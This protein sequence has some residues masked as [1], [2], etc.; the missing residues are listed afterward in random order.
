MF[1]GDTFQEL[2]LFI[3]HR[4]THFGLADKEFPGEGVV[5]GYGLVD[6]RPVY[7]ASQD[8]TVAG[9]AVGEAT[10][11]ANVNIGVSGFASGGTTKNSIGVYGEAESSACE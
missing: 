9:G 1:D 5:T 2:H 8:F 11:T 7:A 4:C 10:G 6:G 3:K